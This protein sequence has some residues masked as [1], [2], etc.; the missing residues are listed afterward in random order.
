M[1]E[2]RQ[3]FV[4]IAKSAYTVDRRLISMNRVEI[5]VIL[6]GEIRHNAARNGYTYTQ[7]INNDEYFILHHVPKGNQQVILDHEL[8]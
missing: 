1:P 4:K 7:N 3:R 6:E 8:T 2:S 5:G